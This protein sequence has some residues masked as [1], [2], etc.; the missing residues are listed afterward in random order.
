MDIGDGLVVLDPQEVLDY[1]RKFKIGVVIR[2]WW[3]SKE[4]VAMRI[5][6][7]TWEAKLADHRYAWSGL[8]RT[9]IVVP[10]GAG[11]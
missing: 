9:T 6:I 7:R 3:R 2:K 5:C 11:I 10:R 1:E 8:T 4:K